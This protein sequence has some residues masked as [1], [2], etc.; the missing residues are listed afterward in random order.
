MIQGGFKNF[1]SSGLATTN[2]VF[3][4]THC[5]HPLEMRVQKNGGDEQSTESR[6]T[7]FFFFSSNENDPPR[8]QCS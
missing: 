4:T 5:D 3:I 7:V 2:A 6:A 8:R 1:L